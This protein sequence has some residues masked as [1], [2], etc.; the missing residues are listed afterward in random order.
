[1]TDFHW[2]LLYWPLPSLCTALLIIIT[3][4]VEDNLPPSEYSDEDTTYIWFF[5]IVWPILYMF[6]L[7]YLY[8]KTFPDFKFPSF[9]K[10]LIKERTFRK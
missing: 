9:K 8:N 7:I 10:A 2:F 3:L 5:I 1:M 4:R 6:G